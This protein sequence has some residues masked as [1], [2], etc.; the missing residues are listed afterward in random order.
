MSESFQN[1]PHA[2]AILWKAVDSQDPAGSSVTL[3][4]TMFFGDSAAIHFATTP[5]EV[6]IS[7]CLKL[8]G[9]TMLTF[10]SPPKAGR[11]LQLALKQL[12]LRGSAA[13]LAMPVPEK[14]AKSGRTSIETVDCVFDLAE[15]QTSLFL[16]RSRFHSSGWLKQIK[17]TSKGSLAKPGL[18]I[19]QWTHPET[20]KRAAI[21][22]TRIEV[23]GSPVSIGTYEFTDPGFSMNPADSVLKSWRVPRTSP[24][25]PGIDASQLR[26]IQNSRFPLKKDRAE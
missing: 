2:S 15:P 17:M 21:E 12:T 13:L 10:A 25:P 4:N 8:G 9:G 16:F 23:R 14:P 20:G 6:Q 26:F 22:S 3:Q 19:A 11:E 18:L 5:S 7:N 1:S 24:N